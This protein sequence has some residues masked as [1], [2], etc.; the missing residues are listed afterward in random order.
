MAT[1]L[2]MGKQLSKLE[3]LSMCDKIIPLSDISHNYT[4]LLHHVFF[5][6]RVMVALK[7]LSARDRRVAIFLLVR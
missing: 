7:R 4:I 1:V 5:H 2:H 6:E 3:S